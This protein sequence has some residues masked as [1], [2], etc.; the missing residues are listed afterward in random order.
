LLSPSDE[1]GLKRRRHVDQVLVLASSF[2]TA[3]LGRFAAGPAAHPALNPP[4][5]DI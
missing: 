3:C 2:S 5:K 4:S 1:R